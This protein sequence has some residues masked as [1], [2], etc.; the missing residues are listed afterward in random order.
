MGI[1]L[2]VTRNA[3]YR[4][5]TVLL[6][7]GDIVV[8]YT[9]GVT[10]AGAYREEFYGKERL[11]DVVG[12]S[13]H[14]KAKEIIDRILEDIKSF[15]GEK[16]HHDDLTLVILKAVEQVGTLR[17]SMVI[18][19]KNEI[20]GIISRIGDAMSRSGFGDKENLNLQVAVEE[21]CINIMNHGYRGAEGYI[22]ITLVTEPNCFSVI[23]ERRSP[24]IRSN[25]IR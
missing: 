9:D 12:R 6:C 18:A 7:P 3:D 8:L 5:K 24:S 23:I 19:H 10:E 16:K 1:A 2:G 17:R 4:E 21:A 11:A 25:S 22:S 13:C 15:I 20:P 14:E